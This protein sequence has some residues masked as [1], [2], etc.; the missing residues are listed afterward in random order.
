MKIKVRKAGPTD[1]DAIS[2]L[3]R[4]V[5][6]KHVRTLPW[7][8]KEE[9]LAPDAVAA[10]LNGERNLVFLASTDSVPAG[11]IY[12]ELRSFPETSLTHSY[13]ALH[14]HH[15]AVMQ[16]IRRS[17]VGRALMEEI[18]TAAKEHRVDRLTADY[19]AFNEEAAE[20]FASFGLLPYNHRVWCEMNEDS[21]PVES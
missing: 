11:Y 4:E 19:W 18:I 13:L 17:G 15:I 2:I 12:A 8:F 5:Q 7:L 10:F 1:A 20:F 6:S 9:G 3:N 14:I 21:G 16:S